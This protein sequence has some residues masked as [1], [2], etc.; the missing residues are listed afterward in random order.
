MATDEI[1]RLHYYE[2]QYL[3]AADLEDQQTY[4]R[5]MRRR[6]NLGPHTWG[7]VTGLDLTET[8]VAGDP[9]AVDVFVQPGVAIDGFGREIIVMS[10]VK[11][12]PLLFDSFANQQHRDVWISYDQLQAQQPTGG[13]AQC[14][15]A[16]QFGRIVETYRFEIDPPPP[17]N[18][19]V[20]VNGKSVNPAS[21]DITIPVD[22]SVPYQEFPDDSN[23]PRWLI[24]LGTVNWDGVNHKFLP[25]SPHERLI[26]GR[27][28]AGLV[29]QNIYGPVP[30]PDQANPPTTDGPRFFI[31]P[32]FPAATFDDFDFAEVKGRMQIDG[33]LT[34]KRDVQIHGGQLQFLDQGG[35]D[36]N[37]PLWMQRIA[38]SG[39]IGSDLRVH[40][41]DSDS[42]KTTRLSIGPKSGSTEKAVLAVRA[43]DNV[44]ISTGSMNFGAKTRQMLNLWNANY[45]IGV[46]NGTQYYRTDSAFHWYKGGKHAD[47][48][49]SPDNGTLQLEVDGSGNLNTTADINIPGNINFGAKERQMLNLWNANY[50][51]GI[52]DFTLYF[53]TDS[54]FCW[55]LRGVHVSGRSDPGGG[56]L[57]MKLDSGSNLS[58]SGNF[59]AAGNGTIGGNLSVGGTE[60]IGGNL[61]V[62][63]NLDVNGSSN[64]FKAVPFTFAIKNNTQG[65]RQQTLTYS[66]FSQIYTAF[67]V[68]QGFSIWDN[69]GNTNFSN[70]NNDPDVNAIPQ[71]V[72]VRIIGNP[73]ATQTT[74]EIFCS[75][76]L[77]SNESDNT[78]LFTLV[79]LGRP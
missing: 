62:G 69:D 43:D 68:L 42:D 71:H 70:F 35:K 50:G 73:T 18:D 15:V 11:L 20:I 27:V 41:G 51:I 63:G 9:T 1:L 37:V 6:H 67:V 28:Y 55:F 17:P 48:P 49:T 45:G 10:P 23:D 53:R 65:P 75:E 54:D 5:D 78:V 52:Q 8:P 24:Q 25:A 64:L 13:F 66:G 57:A 19:D 14:D 3:G 2:R 36:D 44:D 32:R 12:D 79:V 46:Q 72:H 7:I 74:V 34:A 58:V 33:R 40:I 4:L 26:N 21:T 31:Q 61:N 30:M 38:G 77:K 39:G 22:D 29:G 76:S 59:T 60:N 56:V 47:D 16:N